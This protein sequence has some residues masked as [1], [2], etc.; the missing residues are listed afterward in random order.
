MK[1]AGG[2]PDRMQFA[3][4]DYSSVVDGAFATVKAIGAGVKN[5][6][7][8]QKEFANKPGGTL[9]RANLTLGGAI[10]ASIACGNPGCG[11][12]VIA[13]SAL[14]GKPI[15]EWGDKHLKNKDLN[16][17]YIYYRY[18]KWEWNNTFGHLF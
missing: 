15:E 1:Y 11:T 14:F 2:D 8:A 17:F 18:G 9:L 5:F 12:L 7:D 3:S 13:A 16:V 4:E 10:G 6:V